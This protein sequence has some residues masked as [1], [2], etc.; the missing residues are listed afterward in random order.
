M[1]WRSQEGISGYS[2]SRRSINCD[3]FLAIRTIL[4]AVIQWY[5]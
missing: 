3:I 4:I 2:P 5:L 1:D